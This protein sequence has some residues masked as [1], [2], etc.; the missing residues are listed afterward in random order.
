[1][2]VRVGRD[3]ATNIGTALAV[4][5]ITGSGVQLISTTLINVNSKILGVFAGNLSNNA[6]SVYICD[7]SSATAGIHSSTCIVA[8]GLAA[9]GAAEYEFPLPYKLTS[10]CV[11]VSTNSNIATTVYYEK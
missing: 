11:I 3:P 7:Y 1:M 10:G 4:S 8:F 2:G 6:T 5:G 9:S